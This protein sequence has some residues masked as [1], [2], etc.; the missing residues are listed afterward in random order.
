MQPL[1]PSWSHGALV[2]KMMGKVLKYGREKWMREQMPEKG[3]WVVVNLS[4]SAEKRMQ[5]VVPSYIWT[6]LE[7]R[8]DSE[9]WELYS[10]A[11]E[12][13]RERER[14]AGKNKSAGEHKTERERER[15]EGWGWGNV[16]KH[17]HQRERRRENKTDRACFLRLAEMRMCQ[18][19]LPSVRSVFVFTVHRQ[20]YFHFFTCT[21]VSLW[22]GGLSVSK[23]L[24]QHVELKSIGVAKNT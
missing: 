16:T 22:R 4:V 3:N 11:A 19:V 5:R 9:L 6:W 8:T 23:A 15:E 20:K 14:G 12:H 1:S 13:E 7:L 24:T 10:I 2:H 17:V 21:R 18:A